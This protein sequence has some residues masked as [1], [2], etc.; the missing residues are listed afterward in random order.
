M[1]I[2]KNILNQSPYIAFKEYYNLAVSSEQPSIEA[3][4]ISSFCAKNNFVNARFVNLKFIQ[5]DKFIFFTNYDSPKS[6]E[7]D[8]HDQIAATF[9]WNKINVQ[10]RILGNI[11]KTGRDFNKN[12][13]KTRAL[14]K[15]ALA[16]SSKQSQKIKTYEDV[17][18][19]YNDVV[20]NN[21][22][23]KCP[24]YWGGFGF[25]PYYFEFWEGHQSRLNKRVKYNLSNKKWVKSFL[26]P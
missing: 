15:N 1:I 7:F 9:F 14:S 16:I 20:N 8:S 21:D 18:N 24:N 13:F 12:Y 23:T 11:T 25:K 2:F 5:R 19:N 3:M 6:N 10:I 26:Q 17:K 22:L 4:C